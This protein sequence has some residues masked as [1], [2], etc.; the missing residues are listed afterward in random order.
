MPTNST[1]TPD[2]T[3]TETSIFAPI[4]SWE[5]N[6][7][8]RGFGPL[9]RTET[10]PA[11]AAEAAARPASGA[12]SYAASTAARRNSSAAPIAVAAGIFALGGLAAAGWYAT[13]PHDAG[14]AQLTPG[15]T[16]TTTTTS[17][18]A[19][20]TAPT[21][22]AGNDLTAPAAARPVETA[23]VSPPAS[24]PTVTSRTTTTQTVAARARP[25]ASRS[26]GVAGTFEGWRDQLRQALGIDFY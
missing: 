10:A 15:T 19:T 20:Q 25:A 26:V 5:R 23:A 24:N 21:V 9:R 3:G 7:K 2:V 4:P 12:P 16:S 18:G 14:M 6:R 1:T 17:G 22:R 8:R 11:N 13:Q